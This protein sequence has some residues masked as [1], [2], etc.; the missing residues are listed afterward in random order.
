MRTLEEGHYR[1]PDV[2]FVSTTP[3]IWLVVCGMGV[4]VYKGLSKGIPASLVYNHKYVVPYL[5]C[6]IL[7]SLWDFKSVDL[8]CMS[9]QW[10]WWVLFDFLFCSNEL[11]RIYWRMDNKD[12]FMWRLAWFLISRLPFYYSIVI[13]EM[14]RISFICLQRWIWYFLLN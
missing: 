9:F 4:A 14:V 1:T 11:G 7:D 13:L 10:S 3:Q 6:W 5:R 12:V 2:Y 8:H